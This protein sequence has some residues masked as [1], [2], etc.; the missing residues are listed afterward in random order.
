MT[1]QFAN[2]LGALIGCVAL[3]G[4]LCRH[5]AQTFDEA[6]PDEP[7]AVVEARH[8]QARGLCQRCPSLDAC[9]GWVESLPARRRPT[10]IV[11]GRLYRTPR[12]RVTDGTAEPVTESDATTDGPTLK[13]KATP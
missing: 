8:A 5:K 10:G 13:G 11:A 4:A 12:P 1:E 7:A 6:R 3:P 9:T 2:T